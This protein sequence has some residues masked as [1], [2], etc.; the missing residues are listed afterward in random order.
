MSLRT[1][2]LISLIGMVVYTAVSLFWFF[3]QLILTDQMNH[4]IPLWAHQ[5]FWI[6]SIVLLNG[7]IILFLA[8]LHYKQKK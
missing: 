1:A 5:I 7:S 6:F 2:T 4:P 8:V 3:Y